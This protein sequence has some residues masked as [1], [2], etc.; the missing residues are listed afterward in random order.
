MRL[1]LPAIMLLLGFVGG[2]LSSSPS[3]VA[4]SPLWT[5]FNHRGLP[6]Q[7]LP[8]FVAL[9]AKLSPAVVNISAEQ[10]SEDNGSQGSSSEEDESDPFGRFGQPFEEYELAHPHSLGAGFIINHG[11]YILTNAHVVEGAQQILVTLKDGRQYTAR[12]IGRDTKTDIALIK[13]DASAVLPI[14]PLGDSDQIQVGQWVMAIG[15]PF[16]F[17]HSVTAGIVSAKGRFIPGNY[18]DFIQ[19]DASINPGNSGGPLISLD[20]AVVGVNSAIY[21]R[22]GSNIGIGFAI[23]VNLVKEELPQLSARGKVIRGWLGIYIEQVSAEAARRAKMAEP[24]GARITEVLANGPAAAAG[25]RRGDII[26]EFDHHEVGESQELP[27]LVG[28]VPIGR[29]V[30][31]KILRGGLRWEVPITVVRSDEEKLARASLK[32]EAFGL[33]L[34]ELTPGLVQELD[35]SD[36]HGLVVSAIRPGSAAESSG[37]RVRDV[38]LEVNRKPIDGLTS[39]DRA[40]KSGARGKIDLLLVRRD[41]GTLFIPLNRAE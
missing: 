20:G 12:L 28:A 27:L 14:A 35:L 2:A 16:G 8:D 18:D 13:I 38:I 21:T 33:K 29:A 23:P 34:E 4:A 1:K 37:L 15:N 25:L 3:C 26:I 41:R 5:E 31:V 40:L 7:T 24:S 6:A 11:G 10:R 30:R 19:T 39:Y 32:Q 9:A 22:S 36:S 17:D